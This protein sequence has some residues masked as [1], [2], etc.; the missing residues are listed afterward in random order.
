MRLDKFL[1]HS[2]I[3]TRSEVKTILKKGQVSVNGAVIKDAGFDV[4]EASDKVVCRGEEIG[5]RKHICYALNK[6]AGYVCSTSDE[7]GESVYKLLPEE[8]RNRIQAVGRLDKDTTGLLI[9]TDNGDWAHKVL[10]PNHHVA[11]TYEV[12]CE[13]EITDEDIA[14]L[15]AGISI[16]DGETAAPAR[17]ERVGT[18]SFAGTDRIDSGKRI[19]LTIEEGKY[20]QIKRMMRSTANKVIGLKRISFGNISLDDLNIS[21]GTGIILNES[22]VLNQ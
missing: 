11:K 8:F 9:F 7:D 13:K 12:T 22:D 16:G 18:E 14:K 6:P 21:E 4:N 1:A 17:V 2:G 15:E 20:H 19:L 5:Y 10:S 3:G